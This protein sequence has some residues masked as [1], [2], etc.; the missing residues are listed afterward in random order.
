MKVRFSSPQA[1]CQHDTVL[2]GRRL[3]LYLPQ[4]AK[5]AQDSLSGD[6]D[7]WE[8]E[9][10]FQSVVLDGMHLHEEP[11][12]PEEILLRWRHGLGDA[13]AWEHA[14]RPVFTPQG[15]CARIRSLPDSVQDAPLYLENLDARSL[16]VHFR[17]LPEERNVNSP[18][19]KVVLDAR[20]RLPVT[21]PVLPAGSAA[22]WLVAFVDGEPMDAVELR[23][24]PGAADWSHVELD[25]APHALGEVGQDGQVEVAIP[26][27]LVGSGAVDALLVN[28][29]GA[30][31]HLTFDP[32]QDGQAGSF[33]LILEAGQLPPGSLA[34]LHVADLHVHTRTKGKQRLPIQ[35]AYHRR[36]LR[37]WPS[38]PATSL[39]RLLS[40]SPYRMRVWRVGEPDVVAQPLLLEARCANPDLRAQA[41]PHH[42]PDGGAE[43]S[44]WVSR[45]CI[46]LDFPQTLSLFDPETGLTLTVRVDGLHPETQDSAR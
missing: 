2:K 36:Y 15:V 31:H 7:N 20:E 5:R 30:S 29:H 17:I 1:I 37:Q 41:R 28:Y 40:P 8:R 46:R 35:V 39:A 33:T 3:R 21:L 10:P 14:W 26:W 44:L 45:D 13:L 38:R 22:Q 12:G 25:A 16:T 19:D 27:R 42:G 34:G 32:E 9:E 4:A 11:C 6:Y 18:R 43:V 23:A 24:A